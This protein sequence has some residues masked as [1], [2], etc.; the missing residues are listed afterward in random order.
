MV[1]VFLSCIFWLLLV[2]GEV[3]SHF[4]VSGSFGETYNT[5][6]SIMENTA[7]VGLFKRYFCTLFVHRCVGR[8]TFLR[9][10]S[11]PKV[12][13]RTTSRICTR[14]AGI[15]ESFWSGSHRP[16]GSSRRLTVRTQLLLNDCCLVRAR[17]RCFALHAQRSALTRV[18]WT[19]ALR[20][21]LWV[22]SWTW[23]YFLYGLLLSSQS[24]RVSLWFALNAFLL[25]KWTNVTVRLWE[26]HTLSHSRTTLWDPLR[27]RLVR[28]ASSY[29]T[30]VA[31]CRCAAL[32]VR[33]MV[34]LMESFLCTWTSGLRR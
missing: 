3:V 4:T 27:V 25:Q 8:P 22:A 29:S 1:S 26:F 5:S 24:A 16:H 9:V 30:S 14:L 28:W 17:L 15:S 7:R 19:E 18:K 6:Y 23:L 12:T 20:G 34:K 10:N 31:A 33:S 11:W 21:L 2:N 32:G 13:P